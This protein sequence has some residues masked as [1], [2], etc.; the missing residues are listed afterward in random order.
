MACFQEIISPENR[1]YGKMGTLISSEKDFQSP[2]TVRQGE[3][4]TNGKCGKVKKTVLGGSEFS[5]RK[6]KKKNEG[7]EAAKKDPTFSKSARGTWPLGKS[8]Q[9]NGCIEIPG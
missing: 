9:R 2:D 6:L 4:M 1:Q 3:T 8:G 7:T 5:T